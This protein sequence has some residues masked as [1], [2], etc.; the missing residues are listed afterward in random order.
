MLRLLLNPLVRVG[1]VLS[2]GILFVFHCFQYQW[3]GL[4]DLK[5]YYLGLNVRPQL[6]SQSNVVI[7][8]ID[9]YSRED[10][11]SPPQFPISNHIDEHTRVVQRLIQADAR[12]IA[13]DVLF[14]QLDPQL[15][16]TA[17]FAALGKAG[18]VILASP[19]RKKASTAYGRR[20]RQRHFW[21]NGDV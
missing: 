12:I 8:A 13:F 15:D 20:V 4:L 1:L 6:E 17:F 10:S 11:F 14:D 18:N 5:I 7:V 21:S 16:L 2:L 3:F 19:W 9:R